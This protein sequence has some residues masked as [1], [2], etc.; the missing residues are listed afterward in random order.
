MSK[1]RTYNRIARLYDLLDLPFEH[2]RYK[3]V[4]KIIFSGLSGQ[5]LDAG[6]GTGR[7]MPH[8]PPEA[9]MTGVDLSPGM[10]ARADQR[11]RRLQVPVTLH[12]ADIMATDFDDHSFDCV[13]ATFLFCVLDAEHQTPALVELNRICRPGGEIRIIEYAIS[14]HPVRRAIMRLWAPW[15]RW[16]YGA[17]FDRNTEQYLDAAGLELVEQ[18]FIH[19]DIIKLLVVRR[20]A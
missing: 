13:V 12:Q 16:A 5:V 15:V 18:R 14:E 20:K 19:R 8:Y 3:P 10:L 4:R 1:Q 9:T 2:L 7:N 6:V 17:A 11:Q